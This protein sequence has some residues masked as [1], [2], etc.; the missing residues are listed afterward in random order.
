LNARLILSWGQV[1]P[2]IALSNNFAGS[3]LLMGFTAHIIRN[4]DEALYSFKQSNLT[5]KLGQAMNL[6]TTTYIKRQGNLLRFSSP[7]NGCQIICLLT[8]LILCVL[9][10]TYHVN[11]STLQQSKKAKTR[12]VATRKA[13]PKKRIPTFD[14]YLKEQEAKEPEL[15]LEGIN[16]DSV[17]FPATSDKRVN[18]ALA[19]SSETYMILY[20]PKRLVRLSKNVIRAW[21]KSQR[22]STEKMREG[23]TLEL[24]EYNCETKMTRTLRT[25][26]YDESGHFLINA[27]PLGVQYTPNAAWDYVLPDTLDEE[28]LDAICKS[29][30]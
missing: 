18:W 9:V 17:V 14:E 15:N 25:A 19:A 13:L 20:S 29:I 12:R 1:A 27:L 8:T 3:L 2:I 21:T 10:N 28:E 5:G 16:L 30:K 6:F 26:M 11:A 24:N 7:F 23:F 4:S 22:I